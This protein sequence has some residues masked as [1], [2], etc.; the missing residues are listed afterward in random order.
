M[1]A[2]LHARKSQEGQAA[3]EFLLVLP[4]FFLIIF[5]AVDFGLAMYHYVAIANGVR[6]AARY[7]AVN[8][9]TGACTVDA[10]QN[11]AVVRSGNLISTG[12]VSVR[13]IDRN[14][15]G[16]NST[17]GDSIVVSV[18]HPYNF[19]FVPGA[20]I[21][22]QSCADMRLEQQDVTPGL[23]GGVGCTDAG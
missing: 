19:L 3:L 14:S 17:R 2:T 16:S 23:P 18:N 11:R 10:I 21:G 7:G 9:G 8:C 20:S 12:E 1:V 4:L 22:V 15:D 5:V 6:E 13:W